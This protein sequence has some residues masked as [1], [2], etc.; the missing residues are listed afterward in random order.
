MPPS[1]V[2]PERSTG[3]NTY[4]VQTVGSAGDING[5]GFDDVILGGEYAAAGALSQGGLAFVV[6]GT[7]T[8]PVAAV[9]L[10]TMS[11]AIGF[12]IAGLAAGDRLGASV[13]GIGDLNGDGFD[14]IVI[15]APQAN[16]TASDAG[17][18]Y[19]VF[20]HAGAFAASLDLTTLDGTN[21]FRIDG[22][23]LNS[24]SGRAVSGVGDVNG[25]GY[26]DLLI[27]APGPLSGSGTGAGSSYLLFGSGAGFSATVALSS[28][29]GSN[30]L[31]FDG[32]TLN[33]GS[34][35]S[36]AD[37]SAAGDLNGDG[38]DDILIGAQGSGG[39]PGSA[40]VI[41]GRDFTGS[42]DQ[43]G[44]SG[45]DTLTGTRADEQLVGGLGSDTLDGVAGA[46]VLIGGA[47]DDVLVW[48]EGLRHGDGG[49]GTDTLHIDGAG[50]TL[51]FTLLAPHTVTGVERIDLTG[52]GANT[53]NLDFRDVLALSD[54][55]SLRIDGNADD[56][57][58]STGQG[59]TLHAG[60]P[61]LVGSQ[62]YDRYLHLGGEL[63]VD[64]DITQTGI[65]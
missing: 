17:S 56:T 26:A 35:I 45:N 4:Q 3:P 61:V 5:D 28:I 22:V 42:V 7:D 55:Q 25:D 39:P 15:G 30:G 31:R 49:S 52:S 64:S 27:G 34:D 33:T 38:Y 32:R 20:G 29:N 21:G 53:L 50:V 46:D 12:R 51:D 1:F 9:D 2:F 41:F 6:F 60:G 36:G 43:Q 58:T 37:V 47:G 65:S 57:V 16:S 10:G 48:H 8:A 24:N 14:D 54:T 23:S 19:V 40:Y 13:S 59:W 11:T 44:T 63:F 62:L 18:S